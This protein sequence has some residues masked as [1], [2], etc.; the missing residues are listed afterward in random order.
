MQKKYFEFT[1]GEKIPQEVIDGKMKIKNRLAI[2]GVLF[3]KNK[4]LMIKTSKGDYKFPGGGKEK[5]EEDFQTLNRE[6][7]EETGF[8]NLINDESQIELIGKT[9]TQNIDT[10]N[11][12]EFFIMES[13]YYLVKISEEEFCKIKNVGQDLDDYE[14]ELNFKYEFVSVKDALEKNK[15]LLKFSDKECV[16]FWVERETLVL[17][18]LLMEEI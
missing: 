4:L 12:N 8:A 2:R 1:V 9:F 15:S 6:Y 5:N 14:K 18:K 11:E 17:E 16:N 7:E 10:E 13:R 3:F